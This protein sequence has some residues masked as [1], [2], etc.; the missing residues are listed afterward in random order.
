MGLATDKPHTA[1]KC[2][3]ADDSEFARKNIAKVVSTYG[4]SVVGEAAT[5]TEAVA[6]YDS[7]TPDLVLMDITMPELDGIESL[8]RIIEKDRE[9]KVIVISSLGHRE[10]VRKALCLG[11]SHFV[12]KPYNPS[13]VGMIIKAV[14]D[15]GKEEAR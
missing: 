15:K 8:R 5:G 14:L 4:G 11:A 9:A 13:Y 3:I 2:L 10:M 1:F 7:L 6:L 12:T